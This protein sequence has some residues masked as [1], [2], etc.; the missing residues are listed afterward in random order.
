M[1]WPSARSSRASW[2]FSTVKRAPD[3]FAARSKSIRPSASPISKCSFTQFGR[4]ATRPTL[5]TST[6]SCSSAPT[7]TSSSGTLGSTA[8]TSSSALSLSRSACSA[9]ARNALISLTSSF[10]R[11]ASA[12]SLLRMAL[13]I[14][15]EAALRRSCLVCNS[16]RWARRASSFAEHIIDGRARLFLRPLTLHQRVDEGLRVLANPFDVEH[17]RE[18]NL[19]VEG[20][21][22]AAHAGRGRRCQITWRGRVDRQNRLASWVGPAVARGDALP[23]GKSPSP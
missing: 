17:G 11:S 20:I 21:S 5:R 2:P 23:S 8:S 16:P 6:L 13:P 3:S 19:S 9:P 4:G 15:L 14:S 12:M 7:G 22:A 10:S 1:N 18:S